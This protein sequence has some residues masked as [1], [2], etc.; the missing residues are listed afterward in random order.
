MTPAPIEVEAALGYLDHTWHGL[1][2]TTGA[3]TLK[4]LGIAV[5]LMLFFA[6]IN[7]LGVQWLAKTNTIAVLWKIAV[8]VLTVC[9]FIAVSF[10]P[11]NFTAGGGFAPYGAHGIFAALP[12]GVVFALQG[13]EQAT[14]LAGEAR[15]PQRNVPRAVI[16]A[17][18]IGTLL[19]LALEIA[20]IGAC[21]PATSS[22]GGPAR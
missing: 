19:Y 9:V 12:L 2:K 1:I 7:I 21:T 11:S 13:F 10:Q 18:V 4:G 5:V 6:V 3:L 15:D 8:P 16:G 22:R 20:F 14:Q 17:V